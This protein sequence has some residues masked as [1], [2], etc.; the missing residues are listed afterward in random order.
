MF[1]F[2][3]KSCSN[4]VRGNI[5]FNGPRAGINFND[6]FGGNSSG[7]KNLLFNTCRESGDHGPFN[8]WDR[9]VYVTK[10]RDGTASTVKAWDH[11]EQNMVIANYQ[12]R[13]AIDNDD[14]SCWYNVTRNFLVYAE[15]G[16]KSY[17]GGHDIQHVGNVHAYIS[18]DSNNA[19]V[20]DNAD[21]LE[22]HNDVYVNNTCVINQVKPETY[23]NFHCG[24]AQDTWPI[25][26]NNTVYIQG[27]DVGTTGACGLSEEAF[28]KK[29]GVDQGTVILPG[30]P[31]N[32][33]IIALAK[34]LLLA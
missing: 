16:L 27:A 6:G 8:S 9:Q 29:Y 5:F 23:A 14:G 17:D 1:Y 25:L 28:Q 2:Q 19:C 26:G 4:E 30:P 15:S 3:A 11:I 32:A 34:D 13:W 20:Y 7:A 33:A 18:G 12:S 24:D 31:D 21:Q 10:V 22:G